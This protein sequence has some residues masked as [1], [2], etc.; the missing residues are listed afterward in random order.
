MLFYL[1]AP[2]LL[3]QGRGVRA[4][5][6]RLPEAAGA[7][8]GTVHGTGP[9]LRIAVLGDSTAAGVGAQRHAEALP[10]F[11]AGEVA[12]RTG[13]RV[14]WTVAG[15]TGYTA[16]QVRRELAPGLAN[17][18]RPDVVVLAIG[19][20]DLLAARPLRRFERDVAEL[21]AAVR[22]AAGA[23]VPVLVSA[24][25]PVGRF[26]ALP[27]PMR[28]VLGRRGRAMDARLRRVAGHLP[29]VRHVPFVLPGDTDAFFGADGFHPGPDG[30]RRWAGELAAFV[31][32]SVRAERN[33]R[34]A[35]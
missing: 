25:P 30:Y 8:T 23:P 4:A 15:R 18:A 35:G 24:M 7:S 21:V 31:V 1:T 10:G 29:E 33:A 12:R 11:L 16:D 17:G 22:V 5:T 26:P 3:V 32:E 13:R 20:N 34:P 28:A 6:P 9:P 2:I 14:G 19:A 27:Q